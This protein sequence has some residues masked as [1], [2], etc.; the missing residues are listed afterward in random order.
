MGHGP[1]CAEILFPNG[2]FTLA[3]SE[4]DLNYKRN[5]YIALSR[6][7]HTAESQIQIQILNA[8]YRNGIGVRT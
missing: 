6:S 2:L 4:S 5:D 8:N 7:F 3:D 1:I